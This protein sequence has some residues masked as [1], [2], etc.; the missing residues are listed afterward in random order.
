MRRREKRVGKGRR[1]IGIASNKDRL[2][3]YATEKKK[4]EGSANDEDIVNG[5]IERFLLAFRSAGAFPVHRGS[6]DNDIT[7]QRTW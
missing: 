3:F 4:R 5:F 7:L 6:K 2:F 1:E